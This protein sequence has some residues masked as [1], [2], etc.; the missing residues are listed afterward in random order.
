[1]AVSKFIYR[2]GN[3]VLY[4][5][6]I[7]VEKSGISHVWCMMKPIY[8]LVILLLLTGAASAQIAPD[9][10]RFDIELH[11]GEVVEKT[12]TLKNI[13]DMPIAKISNTPI[14]GDAKD[15]IFLSI[16]EDKILPPQEK[17]KIKIFFAVPPETKP[18]SYTG[19][20]YLL[21]SAPPSMPVSIE[22]HI[23]V[24][25]PESYDIGMSINDAIS[26]TT[27][28]KADETADFDL[29]VTNLGRFR[30]VA[31]IDVPALPDGWSASLFDG[32]DEVP[33]P[34]DI[35]LNPGIS[36]PMKLKIESANPG[37][38]GEVAVKATSL[39]NSSKNATVKASA[40][41]GIAVRGYNVKIELPEKMVAN[42]TYHGAFSIALQ[43]KE[44]VNVGVL[45]PPKLMVIPLTQVVAVTPDNP[46]TANFTMLASG[47]GIYPVIFK[48]RDSS[49]I[50]MPEEIAAVRVVEPNGTVILTG[51]DF[52]YKTVASLCS[53]ENKTVPVITAPEGKLKDRMQ[54]AL[55]TYS[56]VVIL[57][58]KSIVSND[59]EKDLAGMDVKRIEGGSLCE[60]SW[61]FVSDMW[62]NGTST[63]VL[64]GPK[65]IDIFRAYQEARTQNVP[66]VICDENL[67][68]T[69]KSIIS[70]LTKRKIKLSKVL[71]VGGLSED[72]RKAL[73]DMGI[74]VEEVKQ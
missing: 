41:F 8:L 40:E 21:D 23:N 20:I 45:T 32:D 66:L 47:T 37:E 64:S 25:E 27:F 2:L 30:D 49:G 18:G 11:P 67:S 1:M 15:Y 74:S 60:T 39:G 72:A 61:R 3:R 52:L 70:D 19:F 69:T 59:A 24:I 36:H 62:Q 46:G 13:G 35:S 14:S 22:F 53:P 38:K 71:T 58:N 73:T 29:T 68:N 28:A 63:V 17:E 44:S 6:K 57:G 16:P 34:Y 5:E 7:T 31:S 65:D 42:R 48:L 51:E 55:Y 10:E 33:I 50:P 43:V 26:A 54:E 12:L 4:V 9:R 56:R